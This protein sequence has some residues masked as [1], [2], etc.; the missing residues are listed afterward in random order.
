MFWE[1]Y[2]LIFLDFSGF[3]YYFRKIGKCSNFTR[4]HIC[5]KGNPPL[6]MAK[7]RERIV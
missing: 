7:K 2:A 1:S 5:L 6:I 3:L 4:N